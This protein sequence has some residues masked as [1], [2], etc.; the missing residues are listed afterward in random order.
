M[1]S[2]TDDWL[3]SCSNFPEGPTEPELVA[4]KSV[5][6][7]IEHL[8]SKISYKELDSLRAV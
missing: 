1:K 3:S 4:N 7:E 6:S 8:K 2:E 5:P